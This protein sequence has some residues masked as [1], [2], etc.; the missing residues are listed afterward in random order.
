MENALSDNKNK[1]LGFTYLILVFV[2]W[3]SLYVVSKYVLGK[4]PTF[5]ISFLRFT[6]AFMALSIFQRKNKDTNIKEARPYILLIGA[7]GYFFAVGAQ[8]L[9]TKYAGASLASLI[10]SLNPITM[11]IFAAVILKEKLTVKKVFGIIMAVAGVYAILGGK[12]AGINIA[13]IILSLFAVFLW[14]L[15]SVYTREATQKY[16][17]LQITRYAVLV[18]AVCYFP[19]SVVEIATSGGLQIDL[20]C[21]LALIYMG[22]ICTGVAYLLWNKSLAI[23]P[24]GTCSAFY[25]IQPLV[26]TILGVILLKESVGFN[27]FIGLVLIALGVIISLRASKTG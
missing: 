7:A 25:P 9:G 13:G 14:S 20:S 5:T 15:V 21:I 11:M 27:F 12:A 23:L 10:N 16:E 17:S 3:G 6:L 24:A 2:L 26:S 19:V 4:M 1:T 8:L 18:A 22:V